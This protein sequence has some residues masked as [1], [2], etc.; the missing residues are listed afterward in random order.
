M[1]YC[2]KNFLARQFEIGFKT[3]V[4][5]G[6][7]ASSSCQSRQNNDRYSDLAALDLNFRQWSSFYDTRL[8]QVWRI[9]KFL[10]KI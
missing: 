8:N 1:P 7:N 4:T 5:Q 2:H 9:R 3:S 6:G 10:F